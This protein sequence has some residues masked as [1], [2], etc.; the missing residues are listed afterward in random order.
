LNLSRIYANAVRNWP[1]KVLSIGLA[2][3]LF[4]F[5]RMSSLE[6]RFFSV[7][8]AIEN[9]NA[10]MPSGSYPQMI[11]IGLRGEANAIFPVLED[12]IVAYIDISKFNT[13]GTYHVPVEWRKKGTAQGTEGLQITVDP[14]GI[15]F[16]LD[17]KISKLV[18]LVPNFLGQADSG[19]FMTSFS[20]NP[21]QI[22]ADGPAEHMGSVTELHTD[23]IDLAG[24]R[25]DFSG[26]VSVLKQ[27]PLVIVRGTGTTEFR[28]TISR[29]V[30]VRRMS[31]VPVAVTGVR[32]GFMAEPELRAANVHLE[33]EDQAVVEAFTLP[34]DFLRL[35][36]SGI[37]E[38]GIYVLRV[39][40]GTHEG[41]TFSV[42][43][44]EVTVR[45]VFSEDI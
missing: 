11:R 7:P 14:A 36:C 1:A 43:P 30:P 3:I 18:P 6:T 24:R 4:V 28:G 29:I 32:K 26:I 31:D 45:I 23:Y 13:P 21:T 38:S 37:N 25:G 34:P 20:L 41:I 40:T 12:D 17:Y 42:E 9:Q 16:S 8:L 19:F 22:I 5:H 27:D 2:I 33:G 39:Q 35:D 10:M 44:E 15:N